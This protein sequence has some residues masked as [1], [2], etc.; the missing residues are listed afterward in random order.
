M[1]SQIFFQPPALHHTENRLRQKAVAY[2]FISTQLIHC[3]ETQN[4]NKYV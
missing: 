1:L 2:K 4:D 3:H